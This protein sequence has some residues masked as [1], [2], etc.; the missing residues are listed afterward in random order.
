MT[1]AKAPRRNRRPRKT[2]A[3]ALVV[4][5]FLIPACKTVAHRRDPGTA[6]LSRDM[7]ESRRMISEMSHRLSVLQFMVDSHERAISDLERQADGSPEP[8][9]T[10][11]APVA[12]H[13][14]A[15]QITE[16][17]ARP[18]STPAKV[19]HVSKKKKEKDKNLAGQTYTRAFAAMKEKNYEKALVLFREVAEKWPND[20][21]ADNAIYWSGEIHYT[22]KNYSAAISAFRTLLNKYPKG[23]K[24]PDA[25]LKTGYSFLALNDK[26]SARKYLKRVVM[27]H[28]FTTSGAKAEKVLNSLD[29][30]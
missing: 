24:A 20:N 6:T 26:E 8:S 3:A 17:P 21:L 14:K 12:A 10:P 9:A 28:P 19:P 16:G 29:D 5:L 1:K 2:V 18:P 27:E 15:P 30:N 4:A 22:K 25:L 7:E 13:P 11:I 23:S